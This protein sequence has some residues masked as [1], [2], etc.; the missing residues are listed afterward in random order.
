MPFGEGERLSFMGDLAR[1]VKMESVTIDGLEEIFITEDTPAQDT[2]EAKDRTPLDS[3][4][5]KD[6]TGQDTFDVWTVDEAAAHL[7]ISS[8]TV[9]RRLQKG[10]LIGHKV[11][12]QFGMEWRVAKDR[13]PQITPAAQDKTPQDSAELIQ[14]R[15]KV[16]VMTSELNTLREQLQ[17]ASYR[18]GYLSAQLE[19]RNAEIK[20]LMDSQKKTSA[21]TRFWLWFTGQG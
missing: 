15:T 18:N 6:S 9:L 5:G 19:G 14:L 12:G 20:L 4:T 21:W 8:K 2:G 16:E 11:P 3:R 10:T 13:T 7:G 17:G 1:E